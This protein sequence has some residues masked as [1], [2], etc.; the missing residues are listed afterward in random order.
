[1]EIISTFTLLEFTFIVVDELDLIDV[2]GVNFGEG[3][4][5]IL[6]LGDGGWVG[7]EFKV[8]VLELLG[9]GLVVEVLR[10]EVQP[11]S[12]IVIASKI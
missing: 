1:M 6:G 4:V 7:S 3:V 8:G 10:L 11:L 2:P 9:D 12:V 5:V